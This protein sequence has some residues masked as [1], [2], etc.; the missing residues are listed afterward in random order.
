MKYLHYASAQLTWNCSLVDVR[1]NDLLQFVISRT[2]LESR[3][4]KFTQVFR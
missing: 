1:S 2:L 4:Q 3:V